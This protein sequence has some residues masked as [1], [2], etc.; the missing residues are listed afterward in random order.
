M[1][2]ASTASSSDS[3]RRRRHHSGDERSS[4]KRKHDS[5][6]LNGGHER[7]GSISAPARDPRDIPAERPKK[8][9]KKAKQQG[10]RISTI[11][12]EADQQQHDEAASAKATATPPGT[13]T[14]SPSPVIDFDGLSRP[15]RGTR[16]RLEETKEQADKRL[17]KMCDAVRTILECVGEDVDREGLLATP[18]RYAKA[19]LF[20]TKGYQQNVR[21]IVNGA[22]FEEGHNEM[23]IVKDIE[24]FS[25]CEHHLVPFT[26]KMHIGYI[27]D[28]N[29]IGISKLPRI[30]ELFARRLQIQE[31]L[32]KEVANAIME[33]LKPQGVAV[34]MESSHLCMVMR[35]VE[36]TTA[37]T[38]T[39]CVLGC[40]ERKEKTRN[41]FLNLIGI[42]R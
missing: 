20:L 16:E 24:I 36:K 1:D 13:I 11:R 26:G 7:R 18:A 3:G 23:V 37:S 19:M 30:A 9:S 17:A 2:T 35:G 8:K 15:S 38:I 27:P 14:R 39:S 33:V 22:I 10:N 12:E 28:K 42:N 4:K 5:K 41:E 29:V 32:T 25:M 40:F 21:D 34:V 6:H 31:R